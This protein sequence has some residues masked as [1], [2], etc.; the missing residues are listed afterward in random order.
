MSCQQN[1]LFDNN[2]LALPRFFLWG[3]H[4]ISSVL[5]FYLGM[6]FTLRHAPLPFL[7]YRLL[8]RMMHR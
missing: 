6:R 8:R 3:I 5:F 2:A 7:A 4:V 1:H